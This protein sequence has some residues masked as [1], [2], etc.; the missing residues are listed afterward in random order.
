[1]WITDE[2][3]TYKIVLDSNAKKMLFY[4]MYENKKSS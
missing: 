3:S 2:Y 1:M 4:F